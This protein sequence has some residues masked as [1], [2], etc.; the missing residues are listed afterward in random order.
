MNTTIS[1]LFV[2][3][4]KGVNN[5]LVIGLGDELPADLNMPVM[6]RCI[7]VGGGVRRPWNYFDARSM[8]ILDSDLLMW[9][10][11]AGKRAD[12][13]FLSTRKLKEFN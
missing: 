3:Q 6:V 5:D 11:R 8:L 13:R 7:M 1:S 9:S 10:R 4:A 2:S 12:Y